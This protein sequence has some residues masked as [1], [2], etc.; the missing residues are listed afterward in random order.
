MSLENSYL[1]NNLRG[2]VSEAEILLLHQHV[3]H[4]LSDPTRILLLY[5]LRDGPRSVSEL[6]ERLKL[7]QSTISR[8]LRVLRDRALVTVEKRGTS[9]LYTITDTRV[10]DA[11]DLLRQVLNQQLSEQAKLTAAIQCS[12]PPDEVFSDKE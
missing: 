4:A 8:H 5:I 3:C 12:Y 10:T 2:S 1:P 7:P 11:L 6:T 9:N